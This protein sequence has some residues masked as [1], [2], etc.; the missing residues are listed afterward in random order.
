VFELGLKVRPTDPHSTSSTILHTAQ[1]CP[2]KV[3]SHSDY[4]AHWWKGISLSKLTNV[5]IK[6]ICQR[7]RR[8]LSGK[9]H[10]DTEQWKMNLSN[11]K[12]RVSRVFR[13]GL[14][15]FKPVWSHGLSFWRLSCGFFYDKSMRPMPRP[16]KC[17]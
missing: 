1:L 4:L 5:Y 15:L 3:L 11:W 14:S 10:T 9:T 2:R 16:E 13:S 8:L 7:S 12:L 6:E 17:L